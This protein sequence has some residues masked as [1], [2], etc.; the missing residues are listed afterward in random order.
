[1][2]SE[3]LHIE[4][5]NRVVIREHGLDDTE[6]AIPLGYSIKPMQDE[7]TLL[8][9]YSILSRSFSASMLS[10]FFMEGMTWQSTEINTIRMP[11]MRNHLFTPMPSAKKN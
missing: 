2:F 6:L 3:E 1:M 11:V 10:I 4:T 5:W 9:D 8:K 7:E